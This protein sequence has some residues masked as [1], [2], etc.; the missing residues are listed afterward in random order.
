MTITDPVIRYWCEGTELD[1][2]EALGYLVNS[3]QTALVYVTGGEGK[4]DYTNQYYRAY[5]TAEPGKA[6]HI[7]ITS[8]KASVA[9]AKDATVVILTAALLAQAADKA[10]LKQQA[11][12]VRT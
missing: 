7:G 10:R 4:E 2:C 9:R 3:R 8:V 5:V 6:C 11:E 12:A 1:C